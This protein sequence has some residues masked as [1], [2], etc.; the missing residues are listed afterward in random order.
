[1]EKVVQ[2]NHRKSKLIICST[3][4]IDHV[5][6]DIYF[7]VESYHYNPIEE[8]YYMDMLAPSLELHL[9]IVDALKS[10]KTIKENSRIFKA[11]YNEQLKNSAVVRVLKQLETYLQEGKDIV[12]FCDPV[13][14]RL[15]HLIIVGNYFKQLDYLVD[16]K[17]TLA[18]MNANL[19]NILVENVIDYL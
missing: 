7:Y 17:F 6:G 15:N 18:S 10:K 5:L 4:Y 12:L 14:L 1:M 19:H 2:L 9:F 3:D 8:I 13:D 16:Y 11:M